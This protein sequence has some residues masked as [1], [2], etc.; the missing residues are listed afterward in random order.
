MDV[1]GKDETICHRKVAS[2]MR[3]SVV[4]RLL[5]NAKSLQLE[6]ARVLQEKLFVPVH[7]YGSKTMIWKERSRIRAVQMGNLRGL[8]SIRRMDRVLNGREGSC[9]E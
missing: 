1:S 6:C 8:L 5:V 3:I 2:G 4:I 7:M 9:V